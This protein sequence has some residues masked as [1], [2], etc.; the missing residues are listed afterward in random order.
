MGSILKEITGLSVLTC[1]Q[2]S[3]M[4]FGILMVQG[5]VNSFGTVVMAAFAAAVKIDSFAYSPVQD[6]GNAFS[7]YVAQ[8]YGAGKMDRIKEGMKK[9]VLL[10]FVF[11]MAISGA[12]YVF[13]SRLMSLFV[14]SSNTDV[15]AVGAGYLRVEGAFYFGIG[16]LFIFY[17]YFRA[18]GKPSVSVALT[19][20]SLGTRVAL[21]YMLAAFLK[22]GV[23][24]I[25]AA[26]P[27]GWL[28]AD[29]AGAVFLKK[30]RKTYTS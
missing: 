26:V 16:L 22:V 8:N 5:L 6:F 1:V 13:G 28:L 7:T 4:N 14:D 2:Q 15:I 12:V 10:V 9:A 21:A 29:I 17:G 27:V 20:I 18:V 11:C 24:G 25:W 23:I 30:H 19:V 3:V